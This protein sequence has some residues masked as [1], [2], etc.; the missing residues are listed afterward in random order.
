MQPK[1]PVEEQWMIGMDGKRES[2]NSV[3]SMWLDDDEVLHLLGYIY[4]H[5]SNHNRD[6]CGIMVTI[7]ENGHGDSSPNPGWNCSYNADT[8]GKGINPTI[9][10]LAIGKIGQTELFI[11]VMATGV[12]EGKLWI[13]TC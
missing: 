11:F 7:I 9:L 1:R 6:I 2:G 4:I 3:L 8:L 13:Q 5:T 12:K 10:P